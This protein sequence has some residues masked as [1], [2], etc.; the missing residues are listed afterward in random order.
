VVV[1]LVASRTVSHHVAR[2]GKA[3]TVGWSALWLGLVAF[4][5]GALMM[6]KIPILS[7]ARS[8]I[9]LASAAMVVGVG[10]VFKGDRRWPT[11]VGL[12]ASLI[13]ALF[14]IFFF[15]GEFVGPAH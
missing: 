3:T 15:V 1:L 6:V 12:V 9:A 5:A 7:D 4:L 13:P 10:A 8:S 14:W 11:W 2:P